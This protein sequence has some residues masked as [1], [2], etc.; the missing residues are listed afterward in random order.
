M[1]EFSIIADVSNAILKL[2]RESLC[3]EPV[4]VPEAV[5]L[6]TPSDKNS[7]FQL[8]IFLYD[9]KDF[10]EYR[11]STPTRSKNTLQMPDRPLALSYMLFLN[12][13]AQMAIGAETEQRILGRSL[14]TLM[15]NP[16]INISLAHPYQN[17]DE[18][19]AGITL[20]NMTFDEKSKIWSSL[21]MPYQV[22]LF[23][24]VAPVMLSSRNTRE[25]VRVRSLEFGT[26]INTD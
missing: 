23:F 13:K 15:D 26:E 10:S 11:S 1:A 8:G 25:F 2:L 20:L 22:G 14:Q 16:Q 19:D 4:Q 3:P 17:S 12:S 5:L 9:V 18:A 21:S 7:D 24:Q 6:T